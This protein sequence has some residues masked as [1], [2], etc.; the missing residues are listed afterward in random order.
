MEQTIEV[1]NAGAA[2]SEEE[3]TRGEVLTV[4]HGLYVAIVLLAFGLRFINLGVAPLMPLEAAQAWPAWLAATGTQVA[5]AP[6]PTSALFYGL[7][8]LLFFVAG[9]NDVM[10]RLLPALVGTA[11]VVLPWWWRDWIGRGA[12]LAVA[13]LLAVDPWLTV[14]AR[15]ADA[16]GLTVFLG[17][18]TLTALW[19]WQAPGVDGAQHG[20]VGVAGGPHKSMRATRSSVSVGWERTLAVG[21]GLLVVSGAQAWSWTPVLVAFGWLYVFR[22]GFVWPRRSSWLWFGAALMLGASGLLT[23]PEAVGAIGTSLT[24]WLGQWTGILAPGVSNTCW[25]AAGRRCGCWSTSHF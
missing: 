22:G 15:T 16:T 1:D 20:H 14:L 13:L 2:T 12:A 23:R 10:A 5:G 21:L 25:A 3:G 4:E 9:A 18:L 7:Q 19:R 6:V 24:A 11:L 17:L 8:S